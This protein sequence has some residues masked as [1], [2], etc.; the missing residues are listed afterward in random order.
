MKVAKY[1]IVAIVI[2]AI[3]YNSVYFKKL[4]EV[5][6]VKASTEFNAAK[7]AQIFWATKL[8]PNLNKA[9]D[10]TKLSS[11]LSSDP[12]TTIDAYSHALG[13]GNLR[14]FLVSG[15]G[16]IE[17]VN[18]DDLN[19]MLQTEN[20]KQNIKIVTEYIFG[21]AVRDA[22]GL[23]NINEFNNTMDFNNVSA[24]INKLIRENVLPAFKQH[25][26][27]GDRI[28]FTGAIELNK[29]HLDLSHIEVVP[30]EIKI[31]SE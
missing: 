21:N 24:E 13:I 5:T 22:T 16:T 17:S 10:I 3:A 20:N 14:Y 7:Y 25:A 18:E 29:E 31:S 1:I 11:L 28:S 19:V 8:I 9:T 6:A 27:K 12:T 4:D 2:V 15:K 30:V 23:I 26:K